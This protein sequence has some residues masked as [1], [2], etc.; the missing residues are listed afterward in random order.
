M[1][2]ITKKCLSSRR[3]YINKGKQGRKFLLSGAEI[4]TCAV[5]AETVKAHR[6]ALDPSTARCRSTEKCRI[7]SERAV[8]SATRPV[9][10]HAFK[11]SLVTKML[12]TLCIEELD[13]YHLVRL[14]RI[15][16]LPIIY[17]RCHSLKTVLPHYQD[18]FVPPWEHC[19]GRAR[20]R[21]FSQNTCVIISYDLVLRTNYITFSTLS[22]KKNGIMLGP[23]GHALVQRK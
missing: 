6:A 14:V 5:L 12:K 10:K 20:I 13:R 19:T 15:Y 7:G 11:I 3:N 21:D 1:S 22:S 16:Y 4:R 8:L 9:I 18:F 2:R 23:T 17:S